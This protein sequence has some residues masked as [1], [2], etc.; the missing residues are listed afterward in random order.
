MAAG[1]GQVGGI[2]VEVLAAAAA[3][4][5]RA[6]QDDV[7]RTRGEGVAQV[8]KG[9]ADPPIAVGGVSA[10]R[11]VAPSVVAAPDA[12]IGLG[13]VLGTSDAESRVGA[14]FA[15]SWHG[16]TPERR[17]LP[18][19]TLGCGKMFTDPARFPCYRLILSKVYAR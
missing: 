6:E 17:V 5:L 10:P 8:I 2:G 11:A 9:A 12:E 7:A 19:D 14:I 18:G 3:V 16:I 13:Q 4:V 15:G 1:V